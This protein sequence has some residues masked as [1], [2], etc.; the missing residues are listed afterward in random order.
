MIGSSVFVVLVAA[1]ATYYFLKPNKPQTAPETKKTQSMSEAERSPSAFGN[2]DYS[3]SP[4]TEDDGSQG[5]T[6]GPALE[7]AEGNPAGDVDPDSNPVE[8]ENV[9]ES[10]AEFMST[11]GLSSG[12]RQVLLQESAPQPESRQFEVIEE[13]EAGEEKL[14]QSGVEVSS[15]ELKAAVQNIIQSENTSDR[16]KTGD[17]VPIESVDTLPVAT[18]KPSPKYPPTAFQQGIEATVVFRALISEFGNV[19]DVVFMNP[20]QTAPAFKKACEDA[21][22]QWRFTPAQKGGVN[23]KVWKTFSIAF[24]K[25]KTE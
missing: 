24:K 2:L 6:Q 17:L 13:Q 5:E 19:L 3:S 21:V 8:P 16:I 18:K 7:G 23:V 22:R 10:T 20:S 4:A 14:A 9:P 12:Q 11:T 15:P 1:G 25:N